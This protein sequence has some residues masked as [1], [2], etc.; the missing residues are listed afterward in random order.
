MNLSVAYAVTETLSPYPGVKDGINVWPMAK[1]NPADNKILLADKPYIDTNETDSSVNFLLDIK[2]SAK[3]E[4]RQYNNVTDDADTHLKSSISKLHLDF[5]FNGIPGIN[6][7]D[8][9]G[10]AVAGG[11]TKK[12]WNG[13]VEF[14]DIKGIG[15]CSFTIFK[16]SKVVLPKEKISYAINGKASEAMIAGNHSTGFLY[17][18]NWYTNTRRYALECAN[19][20]FDPEIIDRMVVISKRADEVNKA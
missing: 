12:S 2:K 11:Y 13:A 14:A 3:Q 7:A 20:K 8:V 5:K 19:L 4:L 10:Y 18:V 1:I 16:I 15:I 6:P 9:I 17:D